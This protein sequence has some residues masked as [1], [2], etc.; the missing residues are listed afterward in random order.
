VENSFARFGRYD[1]LFTRAGRTAVAQAAKEILVLIAALEQALSHAPAPLRDYLFTPVA[2]RHTVLPDVGRLRSNHEQQAWGPWQQISSDCESIC[3]AHAKEEAQLG[4]RREEPDH[5]QRH[6]AELAYG[7]MTSF[8]ELPITGYVN[9][10]YETIA[11]LLYEE[12]TGR[13]GVSL[14]RH[15][16]AVRK[17]PLV[18][19]AE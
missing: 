17:S 3:G 12:L 10:P 14:T 7:L 4:L 16:R 18:R 6:C 8:S 15:C 5:V 13:A 9:G 1:G 11:R 2:A 19:R